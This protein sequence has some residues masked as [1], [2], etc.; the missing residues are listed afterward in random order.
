MIHPKLRIAWSVACGIA[1]LL[2]V[3]LWV[4]SYW[5][6]DRLKGGM[7]K[8]SFVYCSSHWGTLTLGTAYATMAD[9]LR[10]RVTTR[11]GT[12]V[13]FQEEYQKAEIIA[14]FGKLKDDDDSLVMLPHWFAVV[15]MA[16]L[17]IS[18][19]LPW[20]FSLRTLLIATTLVAVGLGLIVWLR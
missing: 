7:S 11:E 20:R 15:A 3:G 12:K 13:E 8:T 1:A 16:T 2:L 4:R 9:E 17:G 6:I 19:L 10:W 14:G 18:P 5:R